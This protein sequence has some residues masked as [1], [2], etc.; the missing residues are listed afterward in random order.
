MLC[1]PYLSIKYD[2]HVTVFVHSD[3]G[4]QFLELQRMDYEYIFVLF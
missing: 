1:L 2:S 3:E 4:N